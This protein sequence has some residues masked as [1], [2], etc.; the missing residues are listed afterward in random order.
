MP[1]DPNE[2]YVVRVFVPRDPV[3]PKG[4]YVAGNLRTPWVPRPLPEGVVQWSYNTNNP[5]PNGFTGRE[6]EGGP[7]GAVRFVVLRKA[8]GS[9]EDS[10]RTLEFR[11]LGVA[12]FELL[13]PFMDP[14]E[15]DAIRAENPDDDS[16][17][18]SFGS[19]FFAGDA[20][21]LAALG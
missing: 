6:I 20:L 8:T 7:E 15:A 13:A 18:R 5:D 21:L 17:R 19:S 2:L 14:R 3:T 11:R 1:L 16:M 9:V 10:P 4:S 12:S